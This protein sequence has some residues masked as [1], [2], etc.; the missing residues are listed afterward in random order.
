MHA[1]LRSCTVSR[2]HARFH[3]KVCE[4]VTVWHR[5]YVRSFI[6]RLC[7]V[8]VGVWSWTWTLNRGVLLHVLMC[9]CTR[10]SVCYRDFQLQ[11][12]FC[13]RMT[14]QCICW[15]VL[16]LLL[17]ITH[18]PIEVQARFHDKV[19]DCMSWRWRL[20][21]TEKCCYRFWCVAVLASRG[22]LLPVALASGLLLVHFFCTA[23]L[24]SVFV[25]QTHGLLLP[26]TQVTEQNQGLKIERFV[27]EGPKQ[28]A[29]GIRGEGRKKGRRGQ[30]EQREKNVRL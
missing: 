2:V 24:H 13:T 7:G 17:P 9:S 27:V 23:W 25:G 30:H 3:D 8:H 10:L 11:C 12:I 18:S 21:R 1:M 5:T 14:P 22:Y 20:N 29:V 6:C 26:I 28:I 15:P 4:Y 19:C 16:R